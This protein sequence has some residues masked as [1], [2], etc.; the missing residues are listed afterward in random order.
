MIG[1]VVKLLLGE[2]RPKPRAA[3]PT[4]KAR[5][6]RPPATIDAATRVYLARA[7]MAVRRIA[8][9]RQRWMTEL[10][11]AYA[12]IGHA[13][14]HRVLD[15][16]GRIGSSYGLEFEQHAH[17]VA[18]I[19]LPPGMGDVHHAM[20]A[21]V[22]TLDRA[23]KVLVDAR[24]QQ[25]RTLLRRFRELLGASR[26]HASALQTAL[27]VHGMLLRVDSRRASEAKKAA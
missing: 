21:W 27:A 15:R 6:A 13:P 3:A 9:A 16:L 18:T 22:D 11:E 2:P 25:D 26:M 7:N 19:Q 5:R 17:L 10:D 23:C 24:M 12:L 14:E 20:T 8:D 1:W 4:R